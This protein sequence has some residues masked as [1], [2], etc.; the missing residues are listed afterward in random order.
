MKSFYVH[1]VAQQLNHVMSLS[2][3]AIVYSNIIICTSIHIIIVQVLLMHII[4]RTAK[5]SRYK[6]RVCLIR[7]RSSEGGGNELSG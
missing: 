3:I 5:K 4:R 1:A 6:E 7:E 2:M